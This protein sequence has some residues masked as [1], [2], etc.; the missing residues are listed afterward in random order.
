MTG[1]A[2]MPPSPRV[3]DPRGSPAAWPGDQRGV[4]AIEFAFILPIFLLLFAGIIQ[5]GA[6]FFLQNNM[7]SV[8]QDTSRRVAV[9]E[10]TSSEAET[11]ANGKLI[12]WGVTY[13]VDVTEPGTDVVVDI[14]APLSQAALIDLHNFFDGATL[15]AQST[16]RRE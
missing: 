16:A 1:A 2:A 15:R 9:G 11:Y 12:N 14:S 3:C 8:A 13:T 5:F 10:M 7:A 4:I 6:I